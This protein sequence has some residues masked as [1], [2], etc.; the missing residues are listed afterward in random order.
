MKKICGILLKSI[1]N[2]ALLVVSG[3]G[4]IPGVVLWY[5]LS[6]FGVSDNTNALV[7]AVLYTAFTVAYTAIDSID[8]EHL[9]NGVS[10]MHIKAK[11]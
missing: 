6:K 9:K 2:I 3:A 1:G 10:W 4:L 7:V 11:C 8:D 5:V